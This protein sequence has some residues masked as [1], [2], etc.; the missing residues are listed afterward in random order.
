M[1]CVYVY[2]VWSTGLRGLSAAPE[3]SSARASDFA[4]H[5]S[6]EAQYAFLY[7][8]SRSRGHVPPLC[9]TVFSCGHCVCSTRLH[10]VL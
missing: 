8:D 6:P 3:A 2:W 4:V 10:A 9:S 1:F 5:S 7:S